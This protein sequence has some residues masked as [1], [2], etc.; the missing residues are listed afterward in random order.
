MLLLSPCLPI[1]GVRLGY[2]AKKMSVIDKVIALVD[3]QLSVDHAFTRYGQARYKVWFLRAVHC[4]ILSSCR[5]VIVHSCSPFLGML[6]VHS[7]RVCSAQVPWLCCDPPPSSCNS[8]GV[9]FR[10]QFCPD[11]VG[12][13]LPQRCRWHSSP[14]LV[15]NVR[16]GIV[17]C[18]LRLGLVN[19]Q[20]VCAP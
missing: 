8:V 7:A 17:S 20:S 3:I 12:V 16:N 11:W 15:G 14:A 10:V 19:Q 18:S 2:T 9:S 5:G 4:Q 1:S 13:F 6:Q